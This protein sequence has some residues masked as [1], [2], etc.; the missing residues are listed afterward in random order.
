MLDIASLLPGPSGPGRNQFQ[1]DAPSTDEPIG[2]QRYEA[3]SVTDPLRYD[4]E[5]GLLQSRLAGLRGAPWGRTLD[6]S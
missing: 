6:L 1:T 3:A 5:M 4:N 2:W